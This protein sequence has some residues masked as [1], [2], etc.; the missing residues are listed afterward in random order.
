MAHN[1]IFRGD[2]H[3]AR[4]TGFKVVVKTSGWKIPWR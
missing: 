2:R 1:P 4:E 3:P